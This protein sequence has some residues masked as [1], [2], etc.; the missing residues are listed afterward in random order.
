MY[1]SIQVAI[2]A[3]RMLV[4]KNFKIGGVVARRVGG[5]VGGFHPNKQ[6]TLWPNL[7]AEVKQDFNSSRNCK[8]GLSVA[9][10]C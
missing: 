10:M 4:C 7:R 6:A 8:L 9:K 5:W 2:S 1:G 3:D